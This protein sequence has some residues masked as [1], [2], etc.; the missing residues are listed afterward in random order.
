M[1]DRWVHGMR[2]LSGNSFLR[3]VSTLAVAGAAGQ[4]IFLATLPVVTRLYNPADFGVAAVFGALL[5]TLLMATSLRYEMAIVLPRSDRQAEVLTRLALFLTMLS[6]AIVLFF[7][8]VW[9]APIVR[10]LNLPDMEGLLW[11]LPLALVGG[12]AYRIFSFWAVRKESFG[13][14]ART[15]IWQS[16]ANAVTQVSVGAVSSGPTGL[17]A[18]QIVG[19]AL[20][21][22]SLSRGA[23]VR[24]RFDRDEWHRIKKAARRYI[25]FPK[26]DLPAALADTIGVQL[27]NLMLA[28]LFSPAVAGFY[29]LAERIILTP[30]SLI[31]QSIGQ[32]I[33]AKSKHHIAEG[34]IIK[35]TAR[36]ST[37]LGLGV[38][39]I[40]IL[41]VPFAH[42]IFGYVF[43]PQ[44][45]SAG[46]YS[47]ILFFGFA[48]Q[49]VYSSI[50]LTLS[51]TNGQHLNL[52]IHVILL[53]GKSL[54]LLYGYV[55]SSALVAIV[56][57]ALVMFIGNVL[58]IA[59]TLYH[60]RKCSTAAL[61]LA[62]DG[63]L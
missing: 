27:P 1:T 41:F 4:A 22:K 31:S 24:T 19:L 33:F 63:R 29:M 39:A 49:F 61:A 59:I 32:V 36:I 58:A 15:R 57:L 45:N 30:L 16:L 2:R 48:A 47:S 35:F 46:Y 37:F 52:I 17:I 38:I 40:G 10:M 51:A 18:G 62:S 13:L 26:Y 42:I 54:A 56:A 60:L 6:A 20:G 7:V 14:I 55:Q 5:S 3:S 23:L 12:G 28:I 43:G 34:N 11:A 8:V 9:R 50:S 44:W 53:V 25:R 21:S